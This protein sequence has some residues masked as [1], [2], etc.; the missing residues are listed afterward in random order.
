MK[1]SI[2]A[3]PEAGTFEWQMLNPDETHCDRLDELE[4]AARV[5]FIGPS[6]WPALKARIAIWR[7]PA[8]HDGRLAS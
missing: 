4:W 3:W 7:N 1:R 5:R 2:G 6:Y 8:A